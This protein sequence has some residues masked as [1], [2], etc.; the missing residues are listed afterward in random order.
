MC[1]LKRRKRTRF[2]G[3]YPTLIK[4]FRTRGLINL[5]DYS[6]TPDGPCKYLLYYCDH[7]IKVANCR[8]L[9]NKYLIAI[10][11]GL[12]SM[13]RVTVLV[14]ILQ[15]D[16]A[17]EFSNVAYDSKIT[18]FTPEEISISITHCNQMW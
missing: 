8:P 18:H 5:I 12:L 13:F 16:N 10:G 7:G 3:S 11:H 4:K 2:T 9:N 17:G 15:S 14:D 6:T 1:M